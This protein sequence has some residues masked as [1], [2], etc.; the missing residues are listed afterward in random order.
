[1]TYITTGTTH[2]SFCNISSSLTLTT[3]APLLKISSLALPCNDGRMLRG[4][5]KIS[6]GSAPK[7]SEAMYFFPKFVS[8]HFKEGDGIDDTFRFQ[9]LFKENSFVM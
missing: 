1:M 7:A 5:R 9:V 3:K 6:I 2:I 8:I 4:G